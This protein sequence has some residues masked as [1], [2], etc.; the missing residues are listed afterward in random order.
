MVYTF[1][2]L[3]IVRSEMVLIHCL[4]MEGLSKPLQYVAISRLD[5]IVFNTRY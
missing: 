5:S 1:P 3:K 2:L 4:I